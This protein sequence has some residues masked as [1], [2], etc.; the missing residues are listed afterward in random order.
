MRGVYDLEATY[1]Q[2]TL[3][4]ENAISVE[5][6]Q[7]VNSNNLKLSLIAPNSVR[8]G[9]VYSCK[10]QCTNTGTSDMI[11]PRVLIND[12]YYTVTGSTLPYIL[13]SGESAYI[14][15]TFIGGVHYSAEMGNGNYTNWGAWTDFEDDLSNTY[16]ILENMGLNL[17][18]SQTLDMANT[19]HSSEGQG[20]IAG[21]LKDLNTAEGFAD[22]I[23]KLTWVVDNKSYSVSTQTDSNGNFIFA[24]LSENVTYTFYAQGLSGYSTNQIQ[25]DGRYLANVNISA[26]INGV[27]SG[28]VLDSA[29]APMTDKIVIASN[30]DSESRYVYTDSQGMYSIDTLDWGN[31]TLTVVDDDLCRVSRSIDFSAENNN[32]IVNFDLNNVSVITGHV[33]N[34]SGEAISNARVTVTSTE[35]GYEIATA[36]TNDNGVYKILAVESGNYTVSVHS[37]TQMFE[38]ASVLVQENGLSNVDFHATSQSWSGK[39]YLPDGSLANSGKIMLLSESQKV[40]VEINSDG[41]FDFPS[42]IFDDYNIWIETDSAVDFYSLHIDSQTSGDI[43]LREQCSLEFQ[44]QFDEGYELPEEGLWFY[45]FEAEYGLIGNYEIGHGGTSKRIDNLPKGNYVIG[46]AASKDVYDYKEFV[47]QSSTLL[48]FHWGLSGLTIENALPMPAASLSANSLSAETLEV[49]A[50][51]TLNK[52]DRVTLNAGSSFWDRLLNSMKNEVNKL[53]ELLG[54]M[55]FPW[56]NNLIKYGSIAVQLQNQIAEL[57]PYK[58]YPTCNESGC[59]TTS[60]NESLYRKKVYAYADARNFLT[61]LKTQY[62]RYQEFYFLFRNLSSKLDMNVIS[63]SIGQT[64]GNSLDPDG[65]GGTGKFIRD[66]M[67]NIIETSASANAQIENHDFAYLDNAINS[68]EIWATIAEDVYKQPWG[69]S[70]GKFLNGLDIFQSIMSWIY[71]LT[72]LDEVTQLAQ[73]KCQEMDRTIANIQAQIAILEKPY[74]TCKHPDKPL[75]CDPNEIYGPVGSDFVTHDE[76]TEDEPF[77]V[78]DGANWITNNAGQENLYTIYFENKSTA[79][80]AAQEIFVTT[81]LPA[82][83]DW[84]SIEVGEISIGNEVYT[85]SDD[86]LIAENIW[87]VDQASTGDQIKIRFDFDPETGEANWYLRSYVATTYD[88]FPESAYDGFLPPN[89]KETHVGEGYVSYRVK[90]DSNLATGDVVSTNATIVFDTNEPIDTNTW[91]NTI[92]ADAPVVQL[93]NTVPLSSSVF[94]QWSG[95]DVGSGIDQYQIY[96]SSDGSAYTL[97]NTFDGNVTS[98]FYESTDGEYSFYIL[99]VD[100]AGN[101]GGDPDQA[102]PPLLIN[103]SD[104][105]ARIVKSANVHAST[106]AISENL[107]SITDWDDFYMEF[108]TPETTESE[109]GKTYSAVIS[110][111]SSLFVVDTNQTIVTPDGVTAEIVDMGSIGVGLSTVMI[112]FTVGED[113]YT[114]P[115]AN[116]Y[117]GAVHFTP[118]L[119]EDSGV[120]NVLEP[121]ALNVTANGK[122]SGTTVKAM[123]YDLDHNN[124]VDVNDFIAFANAFGKSPESLDPSDANYAQTYLA[125]FDGNGV[126]DVQD[127]I[128]FA[129]NYGI[130]KG[131]AASYYNA[132]KQDAPAAQPAAVTVNEEGLIEDESS[133]Q[134]SR[135]DVTTPTQEVVETVVMTLNSSPAYLPQAQPAQAESVQTLRQAHSSALLDLYD[136]QTGELLP[137]E[138]L[139]APAIDEALYQNGEFDFLFDESD[140]DADDNSDSSVDL[141]AVLDELELELI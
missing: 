7:S 35:Y 120:Q 70:L 31:W 89:D 97:W 85:L 19:L 51:L 54:R 61:I 30:E 39:V 121:A 23:V 88:N 41:T 109:A 49:N 133:N 112:T 100:A 32:Q 22:R 98:A 17:T 135:P 37:T 138:K 130:K 78:I 20:I 13:K 50:G 140:L 64:L 129:T 134:P 24:G 115:G 111:D 4:L 94:L 52:P 5:N 42:I 128:A 107:S 139:S 83:M 84:D 102:T 117:W 87:L 2:E 58:N 14:P 47:L 73:Q 77:M 27:V 33:Y 1:I 106:D 67:G 75:S 122:D 105:D 21:S 119:A 56:T 95:S 76:G 45:L 6:S 55:V 62:Q 114:A 137:N 92:D 10:L 68:T 136:N 3:S 141:S 46:I 8:E 11:V 81:T 38:E 53:K 127:F 44:I 26:K 132:P 72:K 28:R 101:V 93:D 66:L 108:W 74:K 126:I 80:A 123:P 125:D 82:G 25:L 43:H 91:L 63:N 69:D 65:V 57:F 71:Q 18:Y 90:Y 60:E 116:T 86:C 118:N 131:S 103:A 15:F 34:V 124:A 9:R 16:D 12:Q 110:Y 40:S 29:G 48:N 113:G 36:F 104:M 99:A 59:T 96:V 79:T